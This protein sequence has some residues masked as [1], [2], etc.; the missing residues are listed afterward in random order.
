M[1]LA[2]QLATRCTLVLIVSPLTFVIPFEIVIQ[3]QIAIQIQIV[4]EFQIIRQQ[5]PKAPT[6]APVGMGSCM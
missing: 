2:L 6:M 3:I 4:I 1:G 5:L